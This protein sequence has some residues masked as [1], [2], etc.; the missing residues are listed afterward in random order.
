MNA[1]KLLILLLSAAFLF[2]CASSE[3]RSESSKF[4]F[5]YEG[6]EYEIVGLISSD[7]ESL[8]D[9]VLRDGQEIVFWARDNNQDGDV[10]EILRGD[11]TLDQANEIY[12][13]GIQQAESQ[14]KYEQR[15][16]PRT[17]EYADESFIYMVV[18]V[19]GEGEEDY[20]LFVTI[21]LESDIETELIDSDMNGRLDEGQLAEEEYIQWQEL[22]EQA[23]E[24][25]INDNRIDLTDEEKYI[26]RV[27]RELNK[28]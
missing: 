27:N 25:G 20:N 8:N 17:F 28:K 9:L 21:D 3:P 7:G 19:T 24:E 14:G 4:E 16:H 26:V 22:Y 5:E 1:L 6:E 13:A 23:L 12:R 11:I 15:Q 10:D 2:G 18:S